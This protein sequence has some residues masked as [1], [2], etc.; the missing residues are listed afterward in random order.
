M[1][2]FAIAIAIFIAL[3]KVGGLTGANRSSFKYKRTHS[4]MGRKGFVQANSYFFFLQS[5]VHSA[6][7]HYVW[8]STMATPALPFALLPTYT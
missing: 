8:T 3:R 6:W 2:R 5:R 4:Y 7:I 1:L